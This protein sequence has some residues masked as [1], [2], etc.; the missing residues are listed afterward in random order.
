[1]DYAASFGAL[2]R[3]SSRVRPAQVTRYD[4]IAYSPLSL[5]KSIMAVLYHISRGA[6]RGGFV[7]RV[8]TQRRIFWYNTDKKSFKGDEV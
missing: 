8:W 2:R 1:M 7:S 6:L 5:V 4:S 3:R